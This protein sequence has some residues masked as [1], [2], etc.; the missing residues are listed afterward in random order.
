MN[1]EWAAREMQAHRAQWA[2]Q[3]RIPHGTMNVAEDHGRWLAG[4]QAERH[5]SPMGHE[6]LGAE[7]AKRNMDQLRAERRQQDDGGSESSEAHR[8]WR[9]NQVNSGMRLREEQED[10]GQEF[11]VPDSAFDADLAGDLLPDLGPQDGT[12]TPLPTDSQMRAS[13]AQPWMPPPPVEPW[14]AG[15][16]DGG[17]WEESQETGGAWRANYQDPR[18]RWGNSGDDW[19]HSDDRWEEGRV[20]SHNRWG[21]GNVGTYEE[22]GAQ[23]DTDER[24][25]A[26]QPKSAAKPPPSSQRPYG[27]HD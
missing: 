10:A 12:A 18:D 9:R 7:Q 5:D 14:Q 20:D 3:Y 2:S 23:A 19:W 24:D 25:A 16:Y 26:P 15:E 11:P 22:S 6:A 13:A 17:R 8:N 1:G 27:P 4:R 21:E